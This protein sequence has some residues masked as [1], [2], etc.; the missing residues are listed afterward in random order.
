[1]AAGT[2]KALIVEEKMT[3]GTRPTLISGSSLGGYLEIESA[4]GWQELEGVQT[5]ENKVSS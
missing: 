5:R 4:M 2:T 3:S 1:L